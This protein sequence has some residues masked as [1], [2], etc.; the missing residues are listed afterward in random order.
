MT[1]RWTLD[2][3]RLFSA[4]L[5]QRAS[6]RRLHALVRD[7]PIVSP[8][9]HVDPALL[10]DPAARFGSPAALF[11]I[12][13]HYVCRLLH[14]RGVPM[15]D[16]G[17]PTRDGRA[18]ERDHRRVWQRFADLFYVFSTTPSGLWLSDVLI[19]VFGVDER[20]D[21]NNAQRVYDHIAE[22]LE[23]PEYSPRALY[24]KFNLRVLCT[25]D[26]AADSL[27]HHRRIRAEAGWLDVRPTFR[28]DAV[29]HFNTPGYLGE[30]E[31]LGAA[32]KISITTYAD[33]IR[34]LEERRAAFKVLGATAT[35]HGA[36]TP[37]AERLGASEVDRIFT[38]AMRGEVDAKDAARFSA[39]MLMEMARMSVEDG[40]VMQ[41]HAGSLRNYHGPL[42]ERFG[43][44]RGADIPVA[45]EWTRNLRPLL[46]AF[47]DDPRFRLILFTLD[48]STYGRELAPLAGFYPAVTLGPPWWFFDSPNGMVRF[49]DHVTETAGL[50][51]TAGFTD[52]TRAFCSIP[53]RH[54]V[55][56]RVTC[57]WL[58]GLVVTGR[59]DEEQA[60]ELARE[61][62]VGLA[63][64]AYRLGA[65][66][67]A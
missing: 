37:H 58:A 36:V 41:L 7:L 6:A 65:G 44:D 22:R 47:G 1:R 45:T 50:Y 28:P 24:R 31:R 55:W 57:N 5:S 26:G 34:A 2:P 8:H 11:V 9:G 13:D 67:Q 64:R 23:R 30:I 49:L 35:D 63:E 10:A 20:L 14:S 46:E 19:H 12:P 42:F 59:L 52:D 18:Y 38:A 32:A 25:T 29:V 17:I 53:A 40:L 66:D 61:C 4:E 21:G 60:A 39:H 51:N 3:D 16:L 43:P 48:E 54:D 56:R 33:Y 62:A 27:E 15:E